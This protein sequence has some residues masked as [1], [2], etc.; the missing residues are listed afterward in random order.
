MRRRYFYNR[1][2]GKMEE[3]TTAVPGA[4]VT[5]VQDAYSKNP[6]VSPIDGSVIGSRTQLR[7]HNARNEVIDVGNDSTIRHPKASENWD[8]SITRAAAIEAYKRLR[9]T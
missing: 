3:K 1:Q 2:T 4:G 8:P 6:V 9:D 5:I 7:E